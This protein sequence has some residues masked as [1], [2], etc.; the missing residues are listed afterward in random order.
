LSQ[1]YGVA[2]ESG[3][4]L[5]IE[6]E[7]G[8]GTIVRIVLPTPAHGAAHP[9]TIRVG[10]NTPTLPAPQIAA[11]TNIL[12]VDDDRQVRRFIGESLRNLGYNVVDVANGQDALAQLGQKPFDLLVVDFAMPGMN[13]AEV[14]RA[15][16]QA[17]PTLKILLVSGYADSDA[18][19]P[20]VGNT[21]L[22]RKPFDV[23]TLSTAVTEILR[24]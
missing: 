8:K 7:L 1:V 19:E 3:G 13:G 11:A 2:R 12:L 10:T 22:L 9:A 18:I 23:N 14:A 4:T 15:A 17:Q 20:L 5:F 21:P 24:G 6:S 16:Q